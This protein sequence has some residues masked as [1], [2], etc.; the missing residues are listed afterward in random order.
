M[1][2]FVSLVC[3]PSLTS[4][5]SMPNVF[6]QARAVQLHFAK[7]ISKLLEGALFLLDQGPIALRDC[8]F[9]TIRYNCVA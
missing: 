8:I 3:P 1:G 4:K 9:V 5:E 6:E 7:P 2:A